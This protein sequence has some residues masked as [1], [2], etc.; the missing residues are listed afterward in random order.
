MSPFFLL[1]LVRDRRHQPSK[2]DIL[3][4]ESIGRRTAENWRERDQL[5]RPGETTHDGA[6]PGQSG[7]HNLVFNEEFP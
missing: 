4:G 1:Q 5:A 2:C 3:R 6:I 7:H